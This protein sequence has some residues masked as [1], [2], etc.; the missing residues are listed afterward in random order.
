ML[1]VAPLRPESLTEAEGDLN[2]TQQTPPINL[3]CSVP[4]E[5]QEV[6]VAPNVTPQGRHACK[7]TGVTCH[8]MHHPAATPPQLRVVLVEGERGGGGRTG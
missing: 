7:P 5:G 6:G 2:A 4:L 8:T 3:S 1:N